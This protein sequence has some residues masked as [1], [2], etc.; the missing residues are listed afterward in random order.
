MR[1]VEE[2]KEQIDY[3][4]GEV[5]YLEAEC[6]KLH[7]QVPLL[8]DAVNLLLPIVQQFWGE[9][10]SKEEWRTSIQAADTAFCKVLEGKS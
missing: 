1:L 10:P 3:L 8:L 6:D 4:K 7:E 5:A 2:L 9:A